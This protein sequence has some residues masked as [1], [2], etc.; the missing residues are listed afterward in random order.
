EPDVDPATLVSSAVRLEGHPRL[1]GSPCAQ[2]RRARDGRL[3]RPDRAAGT[4]ER[5]DQG[6]AVKEET[7]VDGRVHAQSDACAAGVTPP[8]PGAVRSQR[9]ARPDR[10]T[11]T[12]G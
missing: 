11:S 1:P 6:D 7:R 2:R 4:V 12:Q 3:V 9:A 8:C 5:L 10:E